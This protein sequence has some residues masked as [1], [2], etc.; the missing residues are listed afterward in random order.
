MK[1]MKAYENAASGRERGTR[2]L[3]AQSSSSSSGSG[4]EPGNGKTSTLA[5]DFIF[6]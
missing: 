1:N 2:S 4:N 5:P 3:G 6:T